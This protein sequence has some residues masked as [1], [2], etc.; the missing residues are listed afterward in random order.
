MEAP[1]EE[2]SE[3][4]NKLHRVRHTH[5]AQPPCAYI[6]ACR[7]PATENSVHKLRLI[8]EYSL[9]KDGPQHLEKCTRAKGHIIDRNLSDSEGRKIR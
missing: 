7:C 3:E 2:P 6:L 5:A 8:V 1:G 4:D 9:K